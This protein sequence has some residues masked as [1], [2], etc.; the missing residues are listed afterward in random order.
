VLFVAG[1]NDSYPVWYLQ[2]V[3]RVRPDVTPITVP[4]LGAGWYRAELRRR[5]GLGDAGAPA[6]WRGVAREVAAL[7]A[8]ARRLGRP[9]AAS[10]AVERGERAWMGEPG[11]RLHGLIYVADSAGVSVDS[12]A[13]RRLADQMRP[14][15]ARQPLAGVD[16][17]PRRTHET[18]RCPELALREPAD[19][20]E[21]TLLD[22]TCNLR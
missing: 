2:H 10:V 8:S 18:L 6:R 1:D 14:L 7:A 11:W 17:V 16:Q 21:R 9:V 15:L 13:T 5:H 19:S 12:G 3:E 20:A 4:L 22:S